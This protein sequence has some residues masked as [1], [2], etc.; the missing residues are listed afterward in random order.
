MITSVILNNFKGRSE[1]IK[2]DRYNL[3]CGPNGSGKSAIS[4]AA[5]LAI[6]GYVEGVKR[7]NQE[8][9]HKMFSGID[10]SLTT[11]H[12]V[13]F[14]FKSDNI[15]DGVEFKRAFS[16]SKGESIAQEY[17]VDGKKVSRDK[18]NEVMTTCRIPGIFDIESFMEDS[19]DKK[20]NT[21][22]E[23][24]GDL[25]DDIE[26]DS[27]IDTAK[28]EINRL[29]GLIKVNTGVSQKLSVSRAEY[30]L[31]SGSLAEVDKEIE[32]VVAELKL[33]N[34]HLTKLKIKEAERKKEDEMLKKNEETKL[35]AQEIFGGEKGTPTQDIRGYVDEDSPLLEG[36]DAI[37][38]SYLNDTDTER[39]DPNYQAQESGDGLSPRGSIQKIILAIKG[40]GC[41]LCANGAGI[42]V[43]KAELKKYEVNNETD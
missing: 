35:A 21:I 31:P 5:T 34:Q 9:Y 6:K 3:F 37:D 4:E 30:E 36:L 29:N 32:K 27:K 22:F 15:R 39:Q 40:V 20:I 18:Y 19:D 28:T 14:V 41:T 26:I 2:L 23:R 10:D 33:A 38:E 7:Q 11:E 24:F 8:I 13:G 17:F 12:S 1:T 42:M 16:A 25:E 43:A